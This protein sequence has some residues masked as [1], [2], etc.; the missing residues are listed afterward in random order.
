[1]LSITSNS[2]YDSEGLAYQL[3]LSTSLGL[4]L[5]GRHEGHLRKHGSVVTQEKK[6]WLQMI[7]ACVRNTKR[8]KGVRGRRRLWSYAWNFW[9]VVDAFQQ[10]SNITEM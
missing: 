9:Q 4:Y 2:Q 7:R 8:W 1:M 10:K 6:S 3:S 5:D